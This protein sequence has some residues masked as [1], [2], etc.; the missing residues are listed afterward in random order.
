MRRVENLNHTRRG[1]PSTGEAERELIEEGHVMADH[2]HMMC[3]SSH[4][5]LILT[6]HINDGCSQYR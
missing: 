4:H 1:I 3:T 2:V 5:I 6:H